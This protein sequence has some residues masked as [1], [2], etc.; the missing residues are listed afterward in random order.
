MKPLFLGHAGRRLYGVYHPAERVSRHGVVLCYPAVQEYS[1]AHGA[2]R[3][4]AGMLARDGHHVL[5]FDYYGM[6]DSA[7]DSADAT[8]LSSVED[9]AQAAQELREFSGARELSLVGMRLGAAAALL[10]SAAGLQVRQLVLWEPVILGKPYVRELEALDQRRNLMLL[11]AHRTRGRHDELLG[12]RFP[13]VV[14]SLTEAIDLRHGPMPRA[15]KAVILTAE[16]RPE[17]Q[18]LRASMERA[19]VSATVKTI[20]ETT[21]GQQEVR[22]RALLFNAMLLEIRQELQGS[23]S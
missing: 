21:A 13:P 23:P 20:V 12:H 10:A 19:G 17:H 16:A 11:H 15:P 22:E 14:R 18:A 4:L 8:P 3:R 2:F 9:V 1:A 7:G 5:R 6:G